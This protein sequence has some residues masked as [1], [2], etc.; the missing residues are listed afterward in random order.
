MDDLLRKSWLEQISDIQKKN[1]YRFFLENG[2]A[3]FNE[4]FISVRYERYKI[5]EPNGELSKI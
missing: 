3:D 1:F 4:K 2:G 5:K